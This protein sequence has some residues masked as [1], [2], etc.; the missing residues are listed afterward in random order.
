MISRLHKQIRDLQNQRNRETA[1]ELGTLFHAAM[2]VRYVTFSRTPGPYSW[3]PS[4][5]VSEDDLARWNKEIGDL[6]ALAEARRCDLEHLTRTMRVKNT[7]IGKLSSTLGEQSAEI[8]DLRKNL[9][10]QSGVITRQAE[11]IADWKDRLARAVRWNDEQAAIIRNQRKELDEIDRDANRRRNAFESLRVSL[12]TFL[13][14]GWRPDHM[15]YLSACEDAR[16]SL[17]DAVG[18]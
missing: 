9:F 13:L 17:E 7:T 16:R 6:K 1:I 12:G 5:K 10:E 18:C 3:K 8:G 11:E 2:A 15:L 14:L 4:V